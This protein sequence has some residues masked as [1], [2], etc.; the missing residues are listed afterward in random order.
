MRNYSLTFVYDNYDIEEKFP[1]YV[2]LSNSMHPQGVSADTQCPQ[3]AQR[4][5]SKRS[6]LV[7]D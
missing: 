7:V 5:A 6:V 1:K 4:S 2:R 3:A